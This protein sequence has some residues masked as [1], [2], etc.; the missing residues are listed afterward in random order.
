MNVIIRQEILEGAAG[1]EQTLKAL[2]EKQ[3]NTCELIS[4]LV[5]L[6]EEVS[7]LKRELYYIEMRR[8]RA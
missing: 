1:K 7:N 8:Q 2:A 4:E 3:Q 6:R 5:K